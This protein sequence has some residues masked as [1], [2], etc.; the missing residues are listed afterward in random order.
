[1]KAPGPGFQRFPLLRSY[2]Q[3][4]NRLAV[5][6]FLHQQGVGAHLLFLY[7]VGDK[8]DNRVICPETKAEWR[9]ALKEQDEHVGLPDNHLLSAY[10]HKLFL[11]VGES[12]Q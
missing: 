7:F 11:P 1:M 5:L 12:C 6:Y 10:V 2:Y 3:F 4:C 9:E 8:R